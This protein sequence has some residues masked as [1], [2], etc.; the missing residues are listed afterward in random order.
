MSTQRIFP[1]ADFLQLA[2][3][4]PV[5]SIVTQSEHSVVIARTVKPGQRITPH[6]HPAS[7]DTW[8]IVA[9]QGDYIA[10]L[11]GA[12]YPVKAGDVAVARAGEVRGV[13]NGGAVPLVF[14][15][16]VAPVEAGYHVA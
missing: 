6:L 13:H 12:T 1:W 15:S 7:T 11:S 8:T 9:G 10:D 4:E 3:C 5:R 2:D 14:I 16:V